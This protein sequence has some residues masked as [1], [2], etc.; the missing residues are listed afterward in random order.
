MESPIKFTFS[1]KYSEDTIFGALRLL[2]QGTSFSKLLDIKMYGS[3]E[4][5]GAREGV[6]LRG[7]KKTLELET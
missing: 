1:P 5:G 4:F 6:G 7:K 3:G 2:D